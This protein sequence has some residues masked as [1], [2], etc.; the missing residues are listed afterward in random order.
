MKIEFGFRNETIPTKL[1]LLID[2][3]IQVNYKRLTDKFGYEFEIYKAESIE[4]ATAIVEKIAEIMESQSYDHGQEWR[5][6][7]IVALNSDMKEW[8]EPHI[9]NV[10]FRIKDSY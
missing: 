1:Y 10:C 4:Q 3:T 8:Y 6:T 7:E 2:D 5:K 9:F